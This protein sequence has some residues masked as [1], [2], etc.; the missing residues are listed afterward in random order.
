MV[1]ACASGTPP[2]RASRSSTKRGGRVC[3]ACAAASAAM[4]LGATGF[5]VDG[6][7]GGL[8][9]VGGGGAVWP[10]AVT[11]ATSV[12][13][14]ATR[15]ASTVFPPSHALEANGVPHLFILAHGGLYPRAARRFYGEKRQKRVI[16]A[17]RR[18]RKRAKGATRLL[19]EAPAG[20]SSRA[21]ESRSDSPVGV[22]GLKRQLPLFDAHQSFDGGEH[23]WRVVPNA[24]AENELHIAN[25]R[26]VCRRVPS[27]DN[28]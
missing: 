5:T 22:P 11:P 15:T 7:T 6:A 3:S 2:P 1:A 13:A 21:F 24:S 8:L 12:R 14:R 18:V 17:P 23:L 27:H 16:Y 9:G 4:G 25:V 10:R 26:N 19:R 28:Q 20:S